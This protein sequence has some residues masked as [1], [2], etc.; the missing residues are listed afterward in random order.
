MERPSPGKIKLEGP[1]PGNTKFRW[2]F[3]R[4]IKSTF[5]GLR[6][7]DLKQKKKIFL[8]GLFEVYKGPLQASPQIINGLS[9]NCNHTLECSAAANPAM[10]I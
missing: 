8:K 5:F 6:K 4:K 9:H 7:K 1:S 10:R 3:S 2:A